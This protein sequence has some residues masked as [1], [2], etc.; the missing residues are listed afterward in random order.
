MRINKRLW[1]A[2]GGK[3]SAKSITINFE[4]FGEFAWTTLGIIAAI[5]LLVHIVSWF[6]PSGAEGAHYERVCD[7]I[8]GKQKHYV[9]R[10]M[11]GGIYYFGNGP[12][13]CNAIEKDNSV[14]Q[15]AL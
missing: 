2:M 8:A 12:V 13:V 3:D 4:G 15:T 7:M 5:W 10:N 1:T 6:V 9:A 11:Q 14:K